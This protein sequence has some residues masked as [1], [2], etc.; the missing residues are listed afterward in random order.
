MFVISPL[1]LTIDSSSRIPEGC[2]ELGNF[3]RMLL[4]MWDEIEG[5]T[6]RGK[7]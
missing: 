6:G 1:S 4:H 7:T 3:C 2:K 5:E